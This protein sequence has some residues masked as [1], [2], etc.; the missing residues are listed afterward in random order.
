MH[1]EDGERE[2]Q[3]HHDRDFFRIGEDERL[4]FNIQSF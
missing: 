2:R 3:N 4:Y 1:V